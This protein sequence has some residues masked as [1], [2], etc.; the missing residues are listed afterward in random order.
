MSS[1]Y[2]FIITGV[3]GGLARA[4][5]GLY[6]AVNSG[7]EINFGYFLVTVF[8]SGLIGGILGTLF[9]V[10]YRFAALMGYVGTDILENVLRDLSPNK[11]MINK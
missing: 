3:I 6:K 8:S 7:F 10:D 5:F 1:I 11:L 2:I 4:F 9:D